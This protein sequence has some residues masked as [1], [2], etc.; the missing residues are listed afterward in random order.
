MPSTITLA[1]ILAAMATSVQ[2]A[3]G[4][5]NLLTYNVA[6]LP[7]WLGDNGIP[8]DKATNAASIGTLFGSRGYDFIHLQEDFA[9]NDK[10]YGAD[11][12]HAHRTKHSG[13]V[14]FGDGLDT[15]A[16]YP[17]TKG[18]TREKWDTC[19]IIEA[20]C[21]TPKGFSFMRANVDGNEVDLYNLHADA[22]DTEWDDGARSKNLDQ[23]LA[24]IN[25]T[26]KGKA[27]ILAGDFNDRWTTATLSIDKL[28]NAG[29]TDVWVSVVRG[30]QYPVRGSDRKDCPVP[31]PNNK[32]ETVDKV[33]YRSG[34]SVT[35]K[36]T[37]FR[38]ES[39]VFVQKD[40]NKLSDHNPLLVDF[41]WSS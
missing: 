23:L 4:T 28:I 29:F 31:A 38:Y 21:L 22:G 1:A 37:S 8:G 27:T 32:C 26:S 9:Y 34:D 11:T 24:F 5:F 17:W 18:I 16:N 14:P 33:F 40:G 41:T 3:S 13:N 35:L 12:K 2:A 7:Q 36:A 39:K 25:A 20:D 30:G 10:I 15:L 6:G 19:S